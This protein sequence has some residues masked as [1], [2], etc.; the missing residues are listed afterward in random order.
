MNHF[1]SDDVTDYEFV[2]FTDPQFGKT[3]KE[4]EGDGTNWSMD[5]EN[6]AK[7]CSELDQNLAFLMC[8]RDLVHA[9]P[10]DEGQSQG[11]TCRLIRDG[12]R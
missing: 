2:V 6:V 1:F 12:P 9:L 4:G 11:S 5:A 3:D 7:M 10:V 8:A